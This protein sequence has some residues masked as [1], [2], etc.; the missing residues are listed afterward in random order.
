MPRLL[1]VDDLRVEFT[2]DSGIVKAVDGVVVR[3]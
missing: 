1:E 3:G 2:T